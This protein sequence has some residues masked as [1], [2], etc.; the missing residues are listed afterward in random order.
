MEVVYA[1][2]ICDSFITNDIPVFYGDL[3]DL[4]ELGIDI[5]GIVYD[6][7]WTGKRFLK[8][9]FKNIKNVKNILKQIS[10]DEKYLNYKIKELS[11][12]NFKY[13]MLAYLLIKNKNI[14][15]FDYFDVGLN[16]NEQ[17]SLI[18]LIRELKIQG[19]NILVISNNLKFLSLLN[20]T[21]Y[22]LD[23]G[24]IIYHGNIEKLLTLDIIKGK[25]EIVNFINLANRKNAKLN[26]TLDNKELLKDIYR[27][28]C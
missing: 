27:S 11:S 4:Y 14:I 23:K 21:I 1:N 25:P 2:K 5:Q 18:R 7:E 3:L 9:Y 28:V 12:R 8:Y 22:V 13:L 20:Q 26:M 19:K 17:K 16:Y 6:D 15:I 10:F 24:M